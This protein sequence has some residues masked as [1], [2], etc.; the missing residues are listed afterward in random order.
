MV[1]EGEILVVVAIKGLEEGH[2]GWLADWRDW[3]G[4]TEQRVL[5]TR[6]TRAPTN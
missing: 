4:H 2:V 3:M 6:R 5:S 1:S